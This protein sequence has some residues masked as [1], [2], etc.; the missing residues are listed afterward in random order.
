M[1]R[2]QNT[3]SKRAAELDARYAAM[4]RARKPQ[5]RW[6]V[7]WRPLGCIVWL[8]TGNFQ[9]MYFKK[10]NAEERAREVRNTHSE[11]ARPYAHKVKNEARVIR[12]Q[13]PR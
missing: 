4:Y 1:K 8:Q 3:D 10:R 11:L 13:L 9:G 7:V 5:T 12:V 6:L 2:N